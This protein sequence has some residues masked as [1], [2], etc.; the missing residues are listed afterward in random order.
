[1][2]I[3]AYAI[4]VGKHAMLETGFISS[5]IG[6]AAWLAI[7]GSVLVILLSTRFG[8]LWPV[9]IAITMTALSFT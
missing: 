9:G 6:V 3:Y 1:M 7:A 8:R 5:A 4:G 2:A